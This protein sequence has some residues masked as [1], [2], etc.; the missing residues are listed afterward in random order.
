MGSVEK[1]CC[2]VLA[3]TLFAAA[4]TAEAPPTGKL[5]DDARPLAYT[6]NLKIDPR[7]DRF[8]GRVVIRVKLAKAQ[9]HLWLHASE[10]IRL[11]TLGGAKILGLESCGQMKQGACADLVLFDLGHVDFI[12]DTDPINQ[13]V[14]CADS[15]SVTDVMVGGLFKVRNRKVISVDL[16]GLRGRVRDR[17]ARLSAA[18]DQARALA[19]QLEP[20]VVAFAQSMSDEPLAIER[21]IRPG[22]T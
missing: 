1:F 20:H 5:P 15:A 21:Y 3:S 22:R 8:S 9:D 14:T 16:T 2:T 18:T 7:A 12:P 17:V 19:Y 4:A 6:L 13:L 11:A 10:I